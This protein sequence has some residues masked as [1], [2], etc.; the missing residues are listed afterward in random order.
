MGKILKSF[1]VFTVCERDMNRVSCSIKRIIR[2]WTKWVRWNV[3]KPEI[4]MQSKQDVFD[5]GTLVW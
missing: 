5:K 1:L 4:I 2:V 3:H